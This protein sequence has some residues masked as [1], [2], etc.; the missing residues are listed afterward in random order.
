MIVPLRVRSDSA[1]PLGSSFR[2]VK[3]RPSISNSGLG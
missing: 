2:R 1:G 3:W